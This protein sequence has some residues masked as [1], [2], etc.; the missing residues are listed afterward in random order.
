M[1]GSGRARRNSA[2]ETQEGLADFGLQNRPLHF[3]RRR[4]CPDDDI[5]AWVHRGEQT[6]ARRL[7][8]TSHSVAPDGVPHVF[9]DDETKPRGQT[10]GIVTQIRHKVWT[11][12]THASANDQLV[13]VAARDAIGPRE[14]V[15]A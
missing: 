14:H 15:S 13:V 10:L 9:G 1:A 2:L 12:H 4:K 7:E 3:V 5:R 11:N 6:E 8:A